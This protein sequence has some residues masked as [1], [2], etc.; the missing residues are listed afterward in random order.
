MNP[1][2]ILQKRLIRTICNEPFLAHTNPLFL[3]NK[4]IKIP[5]IIE[6]R[7]LI[8][9]FKNIN[10]FNLASTHSYET[11]RELDLRST[12]HRT[13]MTC[14]LIWGFTYQ[15]HMNPLIILQKRLI[16]TICN[17][18]FLAHTNP[19]FLNNKI[20]KIP[21]I[22]E[23]R[24]L[25]YVFKNINSFNLAS[26]HS[27]ETRRELDLRSTFHRTVMTQRSTN[28]VGPTFWNNLPVH[29]RRLDRLTSFKYQLRNFLLS[30]Y[31]E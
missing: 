8:Y 31:N 26:T 5:E 3:N 25:I 4:I 11:R 12:F 10:S 21:E 1:L 9:V 6:Y 18:P 14:N 7:L 19:L 22:I 28:Y 23:Y 20:I 29:L 2:I 15:C 13:V 27:Y 24:L 30:R 17:E 16:R